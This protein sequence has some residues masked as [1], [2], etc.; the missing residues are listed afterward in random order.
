MTAFDLFQISTCQIA[1]GDRP[2]AIKSLDRAIALIDKNG[3]DADMRD[4]LAAL[5]RTLVTNHATRQ[6]QTQEL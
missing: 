6:T 4:E 5:R 3:I 1:E 2:G